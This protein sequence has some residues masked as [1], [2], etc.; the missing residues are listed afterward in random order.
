MKLRYKARALG[1]IKSI[2]EHIARHDPAAAARV[3]RRIESSISRLV[4]FPFSGRPGVVLGTRILVVPRLPYV[5]IYRVREEEVH[6][7]AV[8]HTARHRRS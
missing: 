4:R 7:I 8:L 3:L 5:V 1:H 2:H 6:I